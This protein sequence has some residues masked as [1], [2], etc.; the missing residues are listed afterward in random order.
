VEGH[1]IDCEFVVLSLG[2][3]VFSLVFEQC[4][5]SARGAKV[6]GQPY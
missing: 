5:S 2:H 4:G 1:L 6:Q 3:L